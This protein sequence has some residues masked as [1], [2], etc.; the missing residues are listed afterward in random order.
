MDTDQKELREAVQLDIKYLLG[1]LGT[2]LPKCREISLAI[3]KL[4]EALMWI[5]KGVE[6]GSVE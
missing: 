5:D 6:N 3:T 1:I 2:R 4:E